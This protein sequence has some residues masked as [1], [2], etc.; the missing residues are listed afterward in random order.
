MGEILLYS[1]KGHTAYVKFE[2]INLDS[3]GVLCFTVK[4]SDGDSFETTN[5]SG[6]MIGSLFVVT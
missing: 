5:D 1:K 4:P 3:D 6:G 2:S